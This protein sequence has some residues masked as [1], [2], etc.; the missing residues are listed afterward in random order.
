MSEGMFSP[1]RKIRVFFPPLDSPLLTTYGRSLLPTVQPLKQRFSVFSQ[2][3]ETNLRENPESI[4]MS[5]ID[6]DIVNSSYCKIKRSRG[7]SLPKKETDYF[8]DALYKSIYNM[9]HRSVMEVRAKSRKN[10][11][12]LIL[13]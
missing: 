6:I 1:L 5:T 10:M 12:K 3:K 11:H 13:S 4:Y 8:K 9:K 2:M 7:E